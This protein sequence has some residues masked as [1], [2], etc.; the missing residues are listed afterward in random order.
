MG[1]LL[2]VL[3]NGLGGLSRLTLFAGLSA[4]SGAHWVFLNILETENSPED[5]A[6]LVFLATATGLL[7]ILGL[8]LAF[9]LHLLPNRLALLASSVV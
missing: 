5:K 2:D 7:A 1:T 6:L 4:F 3:N 9:L 8:V